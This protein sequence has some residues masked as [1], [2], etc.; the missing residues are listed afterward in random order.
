[1]KIASFRADGISSY[2]VVDGEVLRQPGAEF[3]SRFADLRAVIA[4]DNLAELEADVDGESLV[5]AGR[6][7]S[8]QDTVCRRQLSATYRGDGSQDT[9]LPGGLRA[10]SR[11]PD[12]T[13]TSH[14]STS[15]FGA[16]RLRG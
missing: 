6:P 2:G 12:R 5:P 9:G 1:M 8:R 16:V 14:H 3:R 10:I 13:R 7:E 11:E 4:A 15:R